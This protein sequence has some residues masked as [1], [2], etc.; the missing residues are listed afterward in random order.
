MGRPRGFDRE[1]VLDIVVDLFWRHGYD[2]TSVE[3]IRCATG[4]G[5]S[6]LYAAFGDKRSLFFEAVDRYRV[7]VVDRALAGLEH[8]DDDGYAAIEAFFDRVVEG[9][10]A[11]ERRWGCMMTNC[12]IECAPRDDMAGDLT[13]GHLM[14]VRQAF[15]RALGNAGTGADAA[16]VTAMATMLVAV[17]QGLNVMARSGFGESPIRAVV[18]AALGSASHTA[19]VAVPQ[20]RP[21]L[22]V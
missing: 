8:G 14:R 1:R 7:R 9:I 10:I 21:M 22:S 2:G 19:L 18:Q 11:G 12:A 5:P 17:L 20:A 3:A 6:S 13:R 15:A 16:Q 4:I